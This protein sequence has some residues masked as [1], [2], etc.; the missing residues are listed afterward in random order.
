MKKY[1]MLLVLI[2]TCLSVACSAFITID[3]NEDVNNVFL[4]GTNPDEVDFTEFF[5][6]NDLLEEDVVVTKSMLNLSRVDFSKKGSFY[7]TIN[8]KEVYKSVEIIV[9]EEG[10]DES[11]FDPNTVSKDRLQDALMEYDGAIGLPSTGTYS[12]LVVPIQFKDTKISSNDLIRLNS[13]FNGDDTGWESVSSYYKKSSYGKLNLSFDIADV[14]VSNKTSYYYEKYSERVDDGN[15]DYHYQYGEEALMLEVLA[16]LEPRMDL[17]KYDVN[18]DG[19]IDAIYLIYSAD[20]EYNDENSIYWAYVSYYI[21]NENDNKTFDGLDVYYYLFAGFDFMDEN[22]EDS[23][24]DSLTGLKVNASTYIHETGH[25][26]GLDDYYD[27]YPNEGSDEGLGCA[28]MMD[29]SV[30]DHNCYSKLMMGW[31]E[32]IVVTKDQT[33]TIKNFESSGDFIMILLDY[34]GSYFSEYLL[35][36]LYSATGLNELHSRLDDSYLFDGEQFGVRIYHVSSSITNPFSDEYYSVT[37]NNN[38]LTKNALIKLIEADG[39]KNFDGYGQA[40]GSDLWKKGM[41]FSDVYP[42]YTSYDY[43]TLWFD[44]IIEDVNISEAKITIDYK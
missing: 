10:K 34:D 31:I 30:G 41:K 5:I 11:S 38:S 44:I 16:Y 20:V 23:F 19:T 12:C 33:L 8:Y 25:L 42:K 14:Y 26:L 35:I 17:T 22:N 36:D 2:V 29:Y 7:V 37:D 1:L 39:D 43:N 9:I 13:A 21:T 40:M 6:I 27:Y 28:D 32:P 4:V 15:G 18:K 24:F 3:V